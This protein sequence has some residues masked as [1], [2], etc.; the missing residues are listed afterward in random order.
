MQRLADHQRAIDEPVI[1]D[2]FA[3]AADDIRR[4]LPQLFLA[5][6]DI[7]KDQT[8]A[9]FLHR[10]EQRLRDNGVLALIDPYR[11]P[12]IGSKLLEFRTNRL[13]ELQRDAAL[14]WQSLVKSVMPAPVKQ[15]SVP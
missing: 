7:P 15:A 5:A 12:A 9:M 11:Q 14:C 6:A 2:I 10:E 3:A 13:P 4:R 1:G 8:Q